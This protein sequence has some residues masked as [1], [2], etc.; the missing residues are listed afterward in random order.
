[1]LG[2]HGVE[3]LLG[4]HVRQPGKAIEGAET[5]LVRHGHHIVPGTVAS[6]A[7]DP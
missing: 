5:E 1:L 3:E 6:P 2:D 7:R 4:D